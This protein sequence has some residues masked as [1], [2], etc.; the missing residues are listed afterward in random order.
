MKQLL[1]VATF[2]LFGLKELSAQKVGSVTVTVSD[3]EDAGNGEI[4][5][6]LFSTSEGFPADRE[7]SAFDGVV[8]EFNSSAVYSFENVPYGEYALSV[9][10]DKN[11]DG[12]VE[13]NFIGFPK[14]PVGALNM[15]GMGKPSFKKS[16]FQLQSSEEELSIK[17]MNQ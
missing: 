11:K 8:K 4:V 5:F 15:S 7:K 3:I 14:E 17:F 13:R 2:S 16:T 9:F 12:V 10:Q 6:M 1:I